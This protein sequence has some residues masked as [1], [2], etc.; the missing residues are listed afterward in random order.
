MSEAAQK[1]PRMTVNE[2]VAW[3]QMRP[4]RHELLDGEVVTMH[5]EGISH[6]RAKGRVYRVLFGLISRAGVDCTVVPDG[7]TVKVDDDTAYEPDCTVHCGPLDDSSVFATNP[8]VIVEVLS[9]ST[10]ALD[11]GMKFA[12][13]FRIPSVRHYLVLD[14]DKRILIH[15]WRNGEQIASRIF[16]RDW[17]TETA[18]L[19]DPPGITVPVGAFFDDLPQSED[20]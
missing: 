5:S 1:P 11:T 9:R 12:G 7:A 20:T 8:L 10:Q 17:S 15:H 14:A 13:Y 16:G 2:F 3:S 18:L 19:L 6:A 4:G